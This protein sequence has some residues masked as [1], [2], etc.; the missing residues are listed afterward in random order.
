MTQN[1]ITIC[2]HKNRFKLKSNSKQLL[3]YIKKVFTVD[4]P[5]FRFIKFASKTESCISPTFTFLPGLTLDI[6]KEIK[7]FDP[8][9]K[10]FFENTREE[11]LPLNIDVNEEDLIRPEN[12]KFSYRDYQIEAIKKS[13]KSGRGLFEF[14]TS[15]GKSLI[16][17]G[18]IKNI[19]HFTGKKTRALILVPNIQL[20]EQMYADIIEYGC[21]DTDISKFSSKY[22]EC[23]DTSIIVS[24]RDWLNLHEDELPNDIDILIV[25]EVHQLSL[26]SKVSKYVNN[27]PVYKKFGFTGTLPNNK[28]SLW[29]VKGL[30][31]PV[32]MVLKASTLQEQNHIANTLIVTVRFDHV[33]KAPEAPSNITCPLERAK[34]RFPLE[35]K[36]IEE[37]AFTNEYI[38]KFMLNFTGN[39]IILYDHIEHGNTLLNISN[40]LNTD[41]RIY[42]I[43]GSIDINYREMVRQEMEIHNNCFLIG[44]TKCIG[45][46]ISIKNIHNIAFAFPSGNSTTKVI[47]AIGRGLRLKGAFEKDHVKLIDFY[48]NYKY[49]TQHFGTRLKLYKENYNLEKIIYKMVKVE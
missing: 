32:L 36:Y 20:V 35:W 34:M 9:C 43:D 23:K 48:H 40:L 39:T 4:N 2:K 13:L 24:N 11:V 25:D 8:K 28:M 17:Y 29:N 3:N 38:C 1:E 30:I 21:S 7:I 12:E 5:N 18:L 31:G 6:I 44:N 37:C 26:G 49:S 16:I 19:W 46:G 47:Q 33:K 15:A 14:A 22:K 45:T 41:K 27:F 42:F 10:I